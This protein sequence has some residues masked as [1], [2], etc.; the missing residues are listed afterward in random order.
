MKTWN[1]IFYGLGI[2][3]LVYIITLLL[4]F[5]KAN[6]IEGY[7]NIS[8]INPHENQYVNSFSTTIGLSLISFLFGFLV[9]IIMLFILFSNPKYIGKNSIIASGIL[10]LLAFLILFSP[11]GEFAMD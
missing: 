4:F 6:L 5:I 11:L 1:R 9:W 2:F 3:P 10:Y 8:S 7:G